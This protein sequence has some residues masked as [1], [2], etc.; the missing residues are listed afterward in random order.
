[1]NDKENTKSTIFDLDSDP[2]IKLAHNPEEPV[3]LQ[4]NCVEMNT[5]ENSPFLLMTTHSCIEPSAWKQSFLESQHRGFHRDHDVS[6]NILLNHT[7]KQKITAS[8]QK[9]PSL[10]HVLNYKNYFLENT[11]FDQK[12][13]EWIKRPSL[14]QCIWQIQREYIKD[15][16]FGH[17]INNKQD[18]IWNAVFN[19]D[20]ADEV[21]KYFNFLDESGEFTHTRW[22]ILG[23]HIESEQQWLLSIRIPKLVYPEFANTMFHQIGGFSEMKFFLQDITTWKC[24]WEDI[25]NPIEG[26]LMYESVHF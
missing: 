8:I 10:D 7:Q 13:Y 11:D 9:F 21:H 15:N 25:E 26:S 18:I 23:Q 20:M 2:N 24:D 3:H 12:Y 14:H 16:R 6:W 4:E 17:Y 19:S 5:P 22:A 1:M